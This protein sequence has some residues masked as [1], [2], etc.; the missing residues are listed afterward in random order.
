[1]RKLIWGDGGLSYKSFSSKIRSLSET[2]WKG[3][4]LVRDKLS[5]TSL[6]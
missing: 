2:R 4:P 5:P 6:S 1:M 3:V